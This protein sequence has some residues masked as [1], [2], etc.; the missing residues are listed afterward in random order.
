MAAFLHAASQQIDLG[1]RSL[2]QFPVAA[3]KGSR[4]VV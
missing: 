1:V 4:E 3:A 2:L